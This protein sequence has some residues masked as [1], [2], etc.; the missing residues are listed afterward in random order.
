MNL[1]DF[2]TSL[3]DGTLNIEDVKAHLASLPAPEP[4]TATPTPTNSAELDDLRA[5]IA[6][7]TNK[8]KTLSAEP[9]DSK[10]APGM[11]ETDLPSNITES[12][13]VR[14]ARM[15]KQFETAAASNEPLNVVMQ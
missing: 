2:K 3:G 11:P 7:L 12:D 6:E 9:G 14:L 4:V 8:V 15:N 5:Q 13:A 1:E 10:S